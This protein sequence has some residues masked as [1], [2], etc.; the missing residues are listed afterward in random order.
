MH[1]EKNV[2][3]DDLKRRERESKERAIEAQMLDSMYQVRKFQGPD[4]DVSKQAR[5]HS[6]QAACSRLPHGEGLQQATNT[7]KQPRTVALLSPRQA[8]SSVHPGFIRET[9]LS[10]QPL[11]Y[12][13]LFQR[14]PSFSETQVPLLYRRLPPVPWLLLTG[15][16]GARAGPD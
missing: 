14:G 2:L 16:E 5:S 11:A 6:G 1:I 15:G 12:Q 9:P 10:Q 3:Y 8:I 4:I 13:L 7:C